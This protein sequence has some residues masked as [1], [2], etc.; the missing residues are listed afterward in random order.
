MT[1][2][3]RER[4]VKIILLILS[5]PY[6]LTKKQ[7]LSRL[8][9]TSRNF[10][11]DIRILRDLS[12]T[13][14][15]E[16]PGYTYGI[17]PDKDFKE[18]DYLSP[19]SKED[20]FH[21]NQELRRCT[22]KKRIYLT[23][24]LESLYDFQKLGLRA[25]RKPALE[26]IDRLEEAKNKKLAVVLKNYLSNS[27]DSRDRR[28]EPFFVDADLDTLQA[29]DVEGLKIRHFRLSRIER[30]V[31]LEDQPWQFKD[32][33]H[34]RESDVFRIA[35]DDRVVVHLELD[36]QGRNVL[37]DTFPKAKG[38]IEA[39]SEKN[40]FNFQSEVNGGFL[41]ITNF[42]LGNADNVKVIGPD[43]LKDHLRTK[44]RMIIEKY[45]SY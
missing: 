14:N 28:V 40:T 44:A 5:N 6:K 9:I 22:D 37:L 18:L 41:G 3:A 16:T 42:I 11:D 13:I 21:I 35:N 10:D 27:S 8:E 24:K 12:L 38:E 25:L 33:H 15:I 39:G 30:V 31:I 23:K 1:M 2:K 32:K 4:I 20:L 43:S 19:L 29:Y 45:S 36:T 7:I 34:K 17:L 26:K